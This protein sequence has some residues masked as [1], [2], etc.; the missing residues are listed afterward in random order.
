MN[1]YA[2]Y[3]EEIRKRVSFRDAAERYGVAF[4]AN[5]AAVCPFH[6][7]KT[8]SFKVKGGYGHCF[9]CG[10]NGDVIALVRE[11][12]GLNFPGAVAQ[13][14]ADFALGLPIGRRETLRERREANRR[15]AEREAAVAARAAWETAYNAAQD[16]YARLYAQL[17][18]YAPANPQDD[19]HPLFAE[20]ANWLCVAVERIHEIGTIQHERPN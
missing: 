14:N 12:L 17:R 1:N 13:L 8:A 18:D 19:F 10:W 6:A 3:A 20:A 2:V 15:K 11:L 5:G 16:E 9:G 4:G 7:E